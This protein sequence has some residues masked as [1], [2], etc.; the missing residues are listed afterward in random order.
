MNNSINP[1]GTPNYDV[2]TFASP[3]YTH[4]NT[5]PALYSRQASYTHTMNELRKVAFF[6]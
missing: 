4:V 3:R 1:D 5:S 6:L 2:L